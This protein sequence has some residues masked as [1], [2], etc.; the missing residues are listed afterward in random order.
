MK[1]GNEVIFDVNSADIW[2]D[3][4][5]E[6]HELSLLLIFEIKVEKK[7]QFRKLKDHLLMIIN[8][9]LNAKN[10]HLDYKVEDIKII[11]AKINE[12]VVI[13]K[14]SRSSA[15]DSKRVPKKCYEINDSKIVQDEFDYL[16]RYLICTLSKADKSKEVFERRMTINPYTSNLVASAFDSFKESLPCRGIK[17]ESFSLAK[18][19]EVKIHSHSPDPIKSSCCRCVLF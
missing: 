10:L 13:V 16:D 4:R 6:C 5:I 14:D 2:L 7:L 3:M 12:E 19:L 18:H 17:I 11:K 9:I 1:I 15:F 8:M